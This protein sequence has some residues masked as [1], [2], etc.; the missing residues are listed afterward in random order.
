MLGAVITIAAFP[1]SPVTQLAISTSQGLA[2]VNGTA[3]VSHS[4]IYNYAYADNPTVFEDES[5][6]K[7]DC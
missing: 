7:I 4:Y 3:T 2:I 1:L 6:E 5:G